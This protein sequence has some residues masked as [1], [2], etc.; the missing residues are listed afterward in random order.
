MTEDMLTVD[1]SD[2]PTLV[3][4]VEEVRRTQTPH[5]LQRDGEDVALLLPV[6]THSHHKESSAKT[7]AD[8]EAFRQS[9][10]SWQ[11]VDTE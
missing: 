5:L 3:H 1:I 2:T 10:G 6:P 9:A 8:Y 11:D 7:L 4:L